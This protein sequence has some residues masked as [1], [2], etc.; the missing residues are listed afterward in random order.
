M[1]GLKPSEAAGA[2]YEHELALRR[3][4][5]VARYSATLEALDLVAKQLPTLDTQRA[6]ADAH[7]VLALCDVP[8]F[9]RD[10]VAAGMRRIIE[11]LSGEPPP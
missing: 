4:P 11:A 6:L 8:A 2:K 9:S 5:D 7:R 3:P 10:Q 1:T